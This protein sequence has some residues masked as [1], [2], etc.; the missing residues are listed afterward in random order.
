MQRQ[1][2]EREKQKA[3]G[4][5]WKISVFRGQMQEVSTEGSRR[6]ERRK[7]EA[8]VLPVKEPSNF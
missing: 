2:I 5:A 3:K 8:D 6:G 1:D 4:R 7:P